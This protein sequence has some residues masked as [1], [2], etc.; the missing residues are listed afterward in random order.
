M[1]RAHSQ[2]REVLVQNRSRRRRST[3][4]KAEKGLVHRRGVLLSNEQRPEGNHP[5]IPV[6]FLIAFTRTLI[7]LCPSS[8]ASALA[9]AAANKEV[10]LTT[11]Q[12][13]LFRIAVLNEAE[14]MVWPEGFFA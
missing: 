10:P 6:D 1:Q 11:E 12:K 14:Q 4:K 3:S 8:D 13:A 9:M 2:R 7:R 5:S